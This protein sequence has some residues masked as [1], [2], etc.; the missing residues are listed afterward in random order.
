MS[1]ADDRGEEAYTHS[2]PVLIYS[3]Q[4]GLRQDPGRAAQWLAGAKNLRKRGREMALPMTR[5]AVVEVGR[6]AGQ[7]PQIGTVT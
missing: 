4:G 5:H 1:G 2:P 6:V 3:R 7:R